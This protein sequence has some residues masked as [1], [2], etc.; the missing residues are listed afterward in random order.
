MGSPV[1][2]PEAL[3]GNPLRLL[4]LLAAVGTPWLAAA[5]LGLGHRGHTAAS[6]SLGLL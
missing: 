1:L 3:G 4:E 6:S 5:S 2:T